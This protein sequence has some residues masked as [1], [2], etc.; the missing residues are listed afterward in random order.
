MTNEVEREVENSLLENSTGAV[1]GPVAGRDILSN[2]TLRIGESILA[3]YATVVILGILVVVFTFSSSSFM[4]TSN[5]TNLLI[6]QAVIA[7]LT[8]AALLPLVVGEFDLSLGYMIGFVAMIGAWVAGH[9]G[10]TAGVLLVMLGSGLA[11]GLINGVLTVV[12]KISSFIATLGVGI[13]LSGITLGLSN[14]EV[15][16]GNI[17][18]ILLAVGRDTFAGVTIAVWLVFALALVLLYVLEHTPLG[19]WWYAIGASERV[20]FLAG[21]RT[22]ALKVAAF[23]LAGTI[24]AIGALFE[25]GSGA[26]ANP[27]FGPELLLPA[28]AAAFLG[29]TTYRP[30]TFNIVGSVVSILVLAVGFDGLSL[31]GVPFWGQPL[32][33]GAVLLAAVLLA[34]AEAR[35]GRVG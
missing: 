1:A 25:L 26:G 11:I 29:V 23:G 16:F 24:V 21:V 10:G 4:T 14:G 28:Y 30:G 7:T 22:N 13:I 35:H 6:T 8:F 5:W 32:F 20:A 15:L 17:P 19:R 34:R 2:R 33:N 31:I 9:G 18:Q 27:T 3:R 12:L